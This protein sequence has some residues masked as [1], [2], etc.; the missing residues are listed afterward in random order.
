MALRYNAGE[1]MA[2][3]PDAHEQY[4]DVR[5]GE[6]RTDRRAADKRQ[7]SLARQLAEAQSIAHIGSWEW[8]VPT[9][10]IHWSDELY[11]IYG[12]PLDQPAPSYEGYLEQIHPDDRERAHAIVQKAYG[13]GLPF[14]YEHRIVRRDGS[15]RTLQARGEVE[16]GPDGTALRMVGTGQDITERLQLDAE[17]EAYASDRADRATREREQARL[18][19]LFELTPAGIAVMNGPDHVYEIANAAYMRIIR[20]RPVIGRSLRDAFP[21]LDGQGYYEMVD[22]VY[23]GGEPLHLAGA[24]VMLDRLRSGTLE[25]TYFDI[26]YQAL[27]DEQA[28]IS[29]VI[30]HAIEVTETVLGQRSRQAVMNAL[31]HDL[32]QPLTTIRGSVALLRRKAQRSELS[33]AEIDRRGEAVDRAAKRMEAMIED[34][35]DSARAQS[36]ETVSI[37]RTRTDLIAL[38][39]RVVAEWQQTDDAHR[40]T[41]EAIVGELIGDFDVI[42][43]ERVMGNLLSNAVKYSRAGSR[44]LVSIDAD[45]VGGRPWATVRVEDHGSGIPPNELARIFDPYFRASNAI[46]SGS[47]IGLTSARIAVE[48]HD[49]TLTAESIAGRGSTFTLRL[50]LREPS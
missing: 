45:R 11:R 40:F 39:S 34:L 15:V 48:Q 3:R 21:E 46:S 33:S 36:G 24:K 9:N 47:G 12:V 19:E 25:E 22:G 42:R 35:L 28:N 16:L 2:D 50:P 6:R 44:I 41:L 13:D 38:V 26:V 8:D 27:H 30:V 5:S 1:H 20:G 32:K 37:D 49:G 43:I 4:T 17:R 31:S 23:A 29:G 10:T 14:A 18:L 7:Q